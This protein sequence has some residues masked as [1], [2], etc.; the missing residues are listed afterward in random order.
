MYPRPID[1][2]FIFD[3]SSR[4]NCPSLSVHLSFVQS[5]E[6]EGIVGLGFPEMSSTGT[7]PIY[8]NIMN[9]AK[10]ERNEFAFYVAKGS[11]VGDASGLAVKSC[12]L[13]NWKRFTTGIRV[14]VEA[15]DTP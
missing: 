10:L 15:P 2:F 13:S 5:I 12:L 6:F 1:G 3:R 7:V 8:D 11:P 9:Q 4:S 14:H